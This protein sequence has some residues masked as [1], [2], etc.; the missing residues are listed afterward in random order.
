[1]AAK[2]ERE[3]GAVSLAEKARRDSELDPQLHLFPEHK[4]YRTYLWYCS[5]IHHPRPMT[6]EEWKSASAQVFGQSAYGHA[7]RRTLE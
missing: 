6:F 5:I 7:A 2:P 4:A 3:G 1:M